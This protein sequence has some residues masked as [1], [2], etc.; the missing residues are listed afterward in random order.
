VRLRLPRFSLRTRFAAA[1]A[2]LVFAVTGIFGG[3]VGEHSVQQL[4]ERIGQSLATDALRIADR[5]NKEMADRSRELALL[6]GLDA[7]RDLRNVAAVQSIIDTLRRNEPDYLWLAVTDVQGRVIAATDGSLVGND[8]NLMPDLREQLRGR[9]T[10]PDDPMRIGRPGETRQPPL[11]APQQINISR[12]IRSPDGSAIGV[13]VAQLSQEWMRRVSQSLLTPDADGGLHRQSF[14][15]SNADVILMGPPAM[16]GTVMQLPEVN[17]AR[18][19]LYGWSTSIWPDGQTYI[20][21]SNFASGDGPFP[22][23]GSSPMNWTVLVR[24]AEA[25]AFA[26]ADDLRTSILATGLALSVL[27]AGL[28]WIIAGIIT[29]PLRQI[30]AAADR[31]RRGEIVEM[32]K[33]RSSIEIETLSASLRAL[34]ATLT[35]K[36][37]QLDELE[38]ATQ[39]DLLTG[40][41]NRAGLQLWLSRALA[42]ARTHPGGLLVL[43]GDLDGFKQVND[44]RGHASGDLLLQEVARRLQSTV[45]G[46]DAVARMGGD[47]FVLVLHAP[48]G[49]AD[50]SAMETAQRVWSRVTEPYVIAGET[51]LIGL[52]LG[53][54]GWPEDDKLLDLVL[55]KADAALYAAKRAGKGRIVFHRE[56]SLGVAS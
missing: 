19:G 45:R 7:M 34:V 9:A 44:T 35:F 42:T 29:R 6:S 22:G 50:R 52:S 38:S 2:V 25:T 30:A 33:L 17:R 13:I 1:L 21:G 27:V 18:A 36:Q 12:P 39:H 43:V 3:V 46:R 11:D 31:L 5:L 26:P 4:R 53:G 49:L 8:L 56:L 23:A 54:A 37:V 15:V 32:P 55:N 24:E 10:R 47:E 14:V 48:L 40:L 16:I 41:L 28:G 51:I 20:T